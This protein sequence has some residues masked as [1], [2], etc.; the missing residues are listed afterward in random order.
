MNSEK[1]EFISTFIYETKLCQTLKF[2]YENNIDEI[3]GKESFRSHFVIIF[4]IK[5]LS[6][7]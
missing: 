6:H 2:N 7:F 4:G 5:R 1:K 3:G